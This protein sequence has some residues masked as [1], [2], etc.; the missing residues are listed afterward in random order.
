MCI[1]DSANTHLAQ[2]GEALAHA[3]LD[4]VLQLDDAQHRRIL[5]HH[6][7]CGPALGDGIYL[8][9][10]VGRVAP[11]ESH[12]VGLHRVGRALADGA[13]RR[14]V[15][16]REVYAAHARL[17]GEGYKF[18]VGRGQLP[19]AQPVALL[20]QHDDGA[21]F[22]RLVGQRRELRRVGQL[23][24][25]NARRGVEG[26]GHAVAQGDRARLVQQQHVHVAGGLHC[27][28]AGG[29][30][31]ALDEPVHAADTDGAQQA[32]DGRRDEADQQGDEHRHGRGRAGQP[33]FGFGVGGERPQRDNGQQKDDRQ[34]AQQDGQGD[35][36]G[37]LLSLGPFNQG[38]H[39]IQEL[40]L[41]HI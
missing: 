27:P 18:G 24:L 13:G 28:A 15:P 31:V 23:R 41:I 2:L 25:V 17:G 30:H 11:A 21:P 1:R 35:L 38:D 14:A 7:R 3:P 20:G 19:P 29:Q 12:D 32:A 10:N 9:V 6:Q 33:R 40:S 26:R 5:G 39:A 37:R 4:D 22:R 16:G 34:P 8:S 36:V